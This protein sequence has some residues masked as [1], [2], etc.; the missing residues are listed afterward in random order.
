MV[1][2]DSYATV[3]PAGPPRL[4]AM[5]EKLA[6]ISMRQFAQEYVADTILDSTPLEVRSEAVD[7]I[8][9]MTI[10]NY[11][12]TSA[13][14]L[15]ADITPLL[16]YIQCPVLVLVGQADRRTPVLVAQALAR[17]VQGAELAIVPNAGH[18]GVLDN[19]SAFNGAVQRFLTEAKS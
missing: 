9:G 8:G 14:I 17:A 12:E 7:M 13:S 3:G 15:S 11:L 18:L 1:L 5:H 2:A 10:A 4:L 16:A 19:P 6:V